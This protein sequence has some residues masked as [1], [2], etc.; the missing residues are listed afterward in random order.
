MLVGD[1]ARAGLLY[2]AD[3]ESGGVGRPS[4]RVYPNRSVVALAVNPDVDAVEVGVVTLGGAVLLRRSREFRHIPSVMEAVEVTKEMSRELLDSVDVSRVVGVGVAVPGLVRASDGLVVRAPHLEW[5]NEDV[6]GAFSA[7][8]E[9]PV[10]VEN[11]ATAGLVAETIFGAA[12]GYR[13]VVYLNGSASGIGGGALAGGM[14]LAGADGYGAELGHITVDRH[15][16]AC[17][18]GRVGCLE[19]EVNI[20]RLRSSAGV[21]RFGPGGL[22]RLL[23]AADLPALEAEA[24]RQAD[25]LA[26]GIGS[27]VSVLNPSIVVLGGFLGD[28]LSAR[29][30]QM[31]DGIRKHT[32]VPM[33]D[34]LTV[35]PAELVA[36][37]LL[38]G[39]AESSFAQVL[40]DPLGVSQ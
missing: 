25:I 31:I 21:D 37:R 32:F 29:E 8:L 2:E 12:R 3:A 36:D 38:V 28:I 13:D 18:C 26:R 9:L 30:Q 5:R 19:S 17:H 15:G 16:V 34:E 40:T 39:V 11:D 4:P 33:A 1:L 10:S 6:V 24:T 7:A 22:P 20:R 14:V 23:A 27:I 35:S